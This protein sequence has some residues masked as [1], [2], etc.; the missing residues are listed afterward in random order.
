MCGSTERLP[1]LRNT[2]R[3]FERPSQRGK[4]MSTVAHFY[5]TYN[6]V[7]FPLGNSIEPSTILSSYSFLMLPSAYLGSD[8]PFHTCLIIAD[9]ISRGKQHVKRS[10]VEQQRMQ[11]PI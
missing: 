6:D 3:I 10:N 2:I 11:L 7:F 5:V 1:A 9:G 4:S 8:G